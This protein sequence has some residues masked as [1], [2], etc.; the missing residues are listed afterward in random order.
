MTDEAT[1]ELER[2]LE[3]LTKLD[4]KLSE[5]DYGS[6]KQ[7]DK[8]STLKF[9]R[10]LIKSDDTRKFAN[11][12]DEELKYVRA[13]LNIALYSE[14]EGLLEVSDYLVEKAETV[15][16]TSLGYKGFFAKLFVTQ[17]K[18]EQKTKEPTKE[19]RGLF[20]AKKEEDEND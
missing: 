12:K 9:F 7:A 3:E 18:R 13:L 4:E 14:A 1:E 15:L 10:E 8:D 2:Q 5:S 19:K 16:A 20:G 17:I 11:L 6:P